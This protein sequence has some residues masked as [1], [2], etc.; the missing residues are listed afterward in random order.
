ML[1][2]VIALKVVYKGKVKTEERIDEG[3]SWIP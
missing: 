1:C 2:F 3:G